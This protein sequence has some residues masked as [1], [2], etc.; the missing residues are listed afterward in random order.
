M[1]KQTDTCVVSFMATSHGH[2]KSV[3]F[4]TGSHSKLKIRSDIYGLK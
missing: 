1:N 3:L 4:K 2:L